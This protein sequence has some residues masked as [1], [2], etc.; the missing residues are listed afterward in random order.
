MSKNKT[1]N[2]DE[3]FEKI[4]RFMSKQSEDLVFILRIHLLIE[5][6]I[7]KFLQ[8]II[9]RSDRVLEGRFSF[10]QKL[11]ILDSFDLLGEGLVKAIKNLNTLRNN[12]SHEVDFS[13][14]ERELDLMGVPLLGKKYMA[15][16]KKKNFEERLH[17]ILYS[18]LGQLDGFYGVY[19]KNISSE[20]ETSK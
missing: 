19:E 2:Q 7:E 12:Y 4:Q 15:E 9:P 17:A 3:E 1:E 5:Q 6:R 8:I 16:H 11:L 20:K 18:M 10:H 14:T 13:I